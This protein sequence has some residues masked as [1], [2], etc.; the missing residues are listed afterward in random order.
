MS[1]LEEVG[2]AIAVRTTGYVAGSP[3]GPFLTVADCD[4]EDTPM[5]RRTLT[6]ALLTTVALAACGGASQSPGSSTDRTPTDTAAVDP[7]TAGP[8]WTDAPTQPPSPRALDR[9]DWQVVSDPRWHYQLLVPRDWELLTAMMSTAEKK[10]R[11]A[12]I[13]SS[14]SRRYLTGLTAQLSAS[15]R[16]FVVNPDNGS[17]VESHCLAK[18][19]E[20]STFSAW[21][22]RTRAAM[23]W[24]DEAT[25]RPYDQSVPAYWVEEPNNWP[26]IYMALEKN[27]CGLTL[28]YGLSIAEFDNASFQGLVD[29]VAV[30]P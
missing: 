2:Q 24:G 26:V 11:L 9:T 20:G 17:L 23:V 7:A 30:V 1:S 8:E 19:L 3:T 18:A 29:S 13:T 22:E 5:I 28:R 14:Q 4:E 27:V 16:W 6:A 12:L 15:F 10:A 21:M 25:I